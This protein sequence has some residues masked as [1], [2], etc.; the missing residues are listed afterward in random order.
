MIVFK[1]TSSL[2]TV[3]AHSKGLFA[4]VSL[5]ASVIASRPEVNRA[6][7]GMDVRPS[8]L[9][10]G[11]FPRPKGAEP[12]YEALSEVLADHDRDH[13]VEVY[14]TTDGI[15]TGTSVR[16]AE[17]SKVNNRSADAASSSSQAY[18]N[19][20]AGNWSY[21]NSSIVPGR[22]R[23]QH[24]Q[25]LSSSVENMSHE[26]A[27]QNDAYKCDV[28]VAEFQFDEAA[29]RDDG[30]TLDTHA[31]SR[32]QLQSRKFTPPGLSSFFTGHNYRND[33]RNS[34]HY[35]NDCLSGNSISIHDDDTL[36]LS[37]SIYGPSTEPLDLSCSRSQ[38][39]GQSQNQHVV[40]NSHSSLLV[41]APEQH[42]QDVYEEIRF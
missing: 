1:I 11:A 20:F 30:L 25:S 38:S 33:E 32:L 8:V 40:E 27:H 22:S 16:Q 24:I 34:C 41:S 23:G 21:S 7:Y 17:K 12:L 29:L 19:G 2:R 18:Q 42:Y 3:D 13:D 14:P 36:N 39:H 4:G 5:E 35:D 37:G 15:S 6:F 26:H 9:L 31:P 28:E 10:S